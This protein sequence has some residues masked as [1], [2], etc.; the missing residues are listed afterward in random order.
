MRRL[1]LRT[2]VR[3]L[4]LPGATPGPPAAEAAQPA[5]MEQDHKA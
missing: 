1:I 2:G 3:R 4:H 5:R